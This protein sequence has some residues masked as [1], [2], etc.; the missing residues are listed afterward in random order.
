MVELLVRVDARVM[1]A[2]VLAACMALFVLGDAGLADAQ[3]RPVAAA[4]YTRR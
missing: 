1:W 3:P 2:A 4:G